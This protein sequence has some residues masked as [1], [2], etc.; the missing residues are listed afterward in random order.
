MR[1]DRDVEC[2][3]GFVADDELR[4]HRERTSDADSLALATRELVR[5]AAHVVGAQA[6]RLEQL[7]D[8]RF[9][10]LPRLRQLVDDQRLA[11]DRAH[12][13]ARIQRRVRILEDDL[14]VA[15][16][17]TQL[18]FARPRDALAFEPDLARGRLDQAQDAAPRRALAAARFADNAERFAGGQ[19]EAHAVDRM[20]LLD[21]AAEP[22]A[23]DREALDEIAD[24]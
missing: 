17:R 20:N 2:R 11:D 18:V 15:R 19:I 23:L 4:A 10:L 24:L 1:L 16:E 22:A 5:V 9:E 8:A 7:D 12:R 3:H 6:H 21:R 13:H 14:H